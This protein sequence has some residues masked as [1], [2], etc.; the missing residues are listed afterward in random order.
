MSAS[1][2]PSLLN[3]AARAIEVTEAQ[4]FRALSKVALH[5]A[6]RDWKRRHNMGRVEAGTEEWEQMMVD[7]KPSYAR[8]EKAKAAERNALRR[9]CTAVRRYQGEGSV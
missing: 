1:D 8:L 9:L 3:I 6:Y 7:T 4:R 2:L 5:D